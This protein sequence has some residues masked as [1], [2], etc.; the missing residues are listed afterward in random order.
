MPMPL[1]PPDNFDALALDYEDMMTRA[2]TLAY[3]LC[4]WW[5][6]HSSNFPENVLLELCGFMMNTMRITME[7]RARQNFWAVI[8]ELR[9]VIRLGR[10]NSY[11]VSGYT[12]ATCTLRLSLPGSAV[13]TKIINIIEGHRFRVQQDGGGPRYRAIQAYQIPVGAAYADVAA[14]NAELVESTYESTGDANQELVLPESPYIDGSISILVNGSSWTR[15]TTGTLTQSKPDDTHFVTKLDDQNRVHVIFGNDVNGAIPPRGATITTGHKIGDGAAGE[16]SAGATWLIEDTVYDALGQA[17]VLV[18]TN[19]ADSSSA[20][21][22]TTVQ[23]A[24]VLG[25]LAST[26]RDTAVDEDDFEN[27]ALSV[28]GIARAAMVT[29]EQDPDIDEDYGLLYLVAR[30]SKLTSGR[31][32][33]AAPTAAQIA[34][35][36]QKLTKAGGKRP[37]M[38]FAYDARAAVFKTILHSVKIRKAANYEAATVATNIRAA[39]ADFYAVALAQKQ[40]NLDID[41]GFRLLGSDGEPDYTIGWSDLFRAIQTAPGV[42]RISHDADGL[43]L[44]GIRASVT[45]LP[46]EWPVPGAITIYDMDNSGVQI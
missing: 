17:T 6:D 33:A 15:Q 34:A 44:D 27:A 42:R 10:A 28:S 19:P 22:G 2:R 43:L 37:L 5:R 31:F 21:S 39:V 24:Q 3:Q 23:Q 41:F 26:T 20:D 35:V 1:I 4:P 32:A 25:P 9:S 7:Q 40:P 14:E 46:H 16:V 30:G 11:Q 29:S 13:A 8:S 18:C 12:A 45:L 38:L 36:E